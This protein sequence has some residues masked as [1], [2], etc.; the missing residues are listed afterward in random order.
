MKCMRCIVRGRV[1]G[2][3]FRDSTR[4]RARELAITGSAVNLADGSVEVIACGDRDA[5]EALRQWLHQGPP[6]ARVDGVS[7]EP[8]ELDAPPVDFGIG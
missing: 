1:Q 2:V 8:A 5:L 3:W 6:L 7:C 4:R